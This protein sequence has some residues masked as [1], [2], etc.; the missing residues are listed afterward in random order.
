MRAWTFL[1]VLAV[2]PTSAL[3]GQDSLLLVRDFGAP[4]SYGFHLVGVGNTLFFFASDGAN[5]NQLWKSDGT[6]AGTVTTKTV[7]NGTMGF[8]VAGVGVFGTNVI[9]SAEGATP[10][11]EELWLSDGSAGGTMKLKFFYYGSFSVSNP[12]QFAPIPGLAIFNGKDSALGQELWKTDGTSAGTVLVKDIRIGSSS[13][14][15]YHLTAMDGIVYFV[16]TEPASGKELWRSDGTEAGTY[17]VK[18]IGSGTVGS[19]P[20]YL[21]VI[22]KTLFFAAIDNVYGQELWKSDGTAAGTKVVKD[23]RPGTAS[24]FGNW[25]T[26]AEPFATMNGIL[27]FPASDGQHGYELWRSDGSESGT[28]MVKD[29]FPGAGSSQDSTFHNWL[30]PSYASVNGILYFLANDGTRGVEIWRTDGTEVGTFLV[31]DIFPGGRLSSPPGLVGTYPSALAALNGML[32]FIG[33]DSLH[34]QELWRSDGTSAGTV[35]VSSVKL[36]N[37]EMV[38]ANGALYIGFGQMLYRIGPLLSGSADGEELS[39]SVVTLHQNYPNPFNPSTTIRYGLPERSH[40]S[41]AVYNTLGQQVTVLQNGEQEAGYHD[42]KF[43]AANLPSGVYFY[44]LQAGSYGETRKLC[45]VR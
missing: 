37:V 32:Y 35:R 29:I 19:Y 24:A 44:R 43:E 18:D 17:M 26:P 15:P 11:G 4:T 16:A 1:C 7:P 13:S 21:Q 20:S 33:N 8:G 2:L 34:G 12:V 23:I 3:L 22:G 9:F 5:G 14:S 41:L 28:Y 45:L 25:I 42:V 39:P 40:V 36:G 10:K 31:K 27:Y 30:N 6:P 38:A